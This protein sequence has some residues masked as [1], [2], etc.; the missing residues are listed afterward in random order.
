MNTVATPMSAADWAGELQAIASRADALERNPDATLADRLQLA[1]DAFSRLWL[2][3][4]PQVI[5]RS[6]RAS[7]RFAEP[8]LVTS[9]D[10][11]QQ[12]AINQQIRLKALASAGQLERP[13]K[14]APVLPVEDV[15]E[16]PPQPARRKRKRIDDHRPEGW[17]GTIEL[18]AAA[19]TDGPRVRYLMRSE[20]IPPELVHRVS[21]RGLWF[22]PQV[23]ELVQQLNTKRTHTHKQP[24]RSGDDIGCQISQ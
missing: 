9:G 20:R 21:R 15:E 1:T 10:L 3:W 24:V 16:E 18:A 8:V 4:S 19:G 17:L 7:A 6:A 23:V 22:A 5:A 14:I 12:L 11:D 13:A 2:A